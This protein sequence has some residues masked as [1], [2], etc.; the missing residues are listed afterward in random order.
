MFDRN[1]TLCSRPLS[2][3]LLN[4]LRT[5]QQMQGFPLGLRA[6]IGQGAVHNEEIPETHAQVS[7]A[8]KCCITYL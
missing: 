3:L 6:M 8:Q 2:R 7:K 1:A 5:H 4:A